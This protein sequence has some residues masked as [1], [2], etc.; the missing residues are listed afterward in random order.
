MRNDQRR[1]LGE[2]SEV[3]EII[4]GDLLMKKPSDYLQVAAVATA[5]SAFGFFIAYYAVLRERSFWAAGAG[6]LIAY[7]A[8]YAAWDA[9][10]GYRDN[11]EHL[12]NPSDS[13]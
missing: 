8:L 6:F 7:S 11:K 3:P 13:A 12:R 5:I 4:E 10:K 1:R 9:Y 2:L